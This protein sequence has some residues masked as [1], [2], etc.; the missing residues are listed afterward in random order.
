MN[1]TAKTLALGLLMA[2]SVASTAAA[3]P[4]RYD[5]RRNPI[6][7]QLHPH[8]FSGVLTIACPDGQVPSTFEQPIYDEDGLFVVGYE[9]VHTCIPEDLEPAG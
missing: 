6:Q 8:T 3:T 2:V 4:Q 7:V 9:T 5:L 1:A